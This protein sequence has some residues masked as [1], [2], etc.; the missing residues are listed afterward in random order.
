MVSSLLGAVDDPVLA[1]L[2]LRG[3][4][5][6]T[7][8]IGARESFRDCQADE[9]LPRKNVG[10]DFALKFRRSEVEDRR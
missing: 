6:E 5:L 1:I 2:R 8:D 9:L 10:D 7:H 3:G 4:G